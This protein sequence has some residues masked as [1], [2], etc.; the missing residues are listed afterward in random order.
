TSSIPSFEILNNSSINSIES[1][2]QIGSINGL[3]GYPQGAMAIDEILT[4]VYVRNIP[5][6]TGAD[7][8]A[9][10]KATISSIMSGSSIAVNRDY[11]I[12][13]V[14]VLDPEITIPAGT[15]WRSGIANII[16]THLHVGLR[17][18]DDSPLQIPPNKMYPI[19]AKTYLGGICGDRI[20]TDVA[21][22]F[23]TPSGTFDNSATYQF[24]GKFILDNFVQDDGNIEVIGEMGLYRLAEEGLGRETNTKATYQV[25]LYRKD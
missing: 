2:G 16:S 25:S 23:I 18:R 19:L 14:G 13:G 1:I 17:M 7:N 20:G 15:G 5:S 3:M 4:P 6:P 22:S 9:Y 12:G 21:F 24:S 10:F 11:M 8:I